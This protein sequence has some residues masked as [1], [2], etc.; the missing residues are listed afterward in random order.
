[1]YLGGLN[2]I[3][4]RR[5]CGLS[6][7][8]MTQRALKAGVKWIQ[9]RDKERSRREIYEEALSL[10]AITTEKDAV[11]VVNDHP[12]IALAVHADGVHLGQDDLPLKEARKLMGKSQIIGIS[13]HTSAQAKDAERGGAD[14]IGFGPV[15]FTET[16]EAGSPTG[17]EILAEIKK[18]VDIPVVAIGGI[19]PENLKAVLETGA[20]AVAVASAILCG[21]IEGNTERFL[22][23]I[24]SYKV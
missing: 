18:L 5:A 20:D 24:N 4:D 10:R 19:T 13:T 7:G 16:K 2:F 3:T 15:F 9:L 1:M 14:Y 23:I 11:F 17:I 8:D 12:D 22:D 21:D 6:Y